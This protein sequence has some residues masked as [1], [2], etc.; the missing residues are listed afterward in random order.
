VRIT[1]ATSGRN[2][3]QL[4]EIFAGN[5]EEHRKTDRRP[6]LEAE[7]ARP[8]PAPLAAGVGKPLLEVALEILACGNV[9]C[10]DDELGEAV[11]EQLLVERQIEARAAIAE[12]ARVI[13]DQSLDFRLVEQRFDLCRLRFGGFQRRAIGQPQVDQEFGPTR[14]REE[15]LL[16][17]QRQ[18]PPATRQRR[19]ASLR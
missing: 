12:V 18:S 19:S 15:L 7:H 6:V 13:P 16:H 8:Q 17:P 10:R 11:V 2:P 4:A 3:S 1:A 9:L 14:R 5:A